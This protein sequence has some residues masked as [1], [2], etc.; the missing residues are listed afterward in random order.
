[1]SDQAEFVKLASEADERGDPILAGIYR[2]E[3]GNDRSGHVKVHKPNLGPYSDENQ[4]KCVDCGASL[5]SARLS[6]PC[7]AQRPS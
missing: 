4:R 5:N 6:E 1:M 7:F 2:V 3:A